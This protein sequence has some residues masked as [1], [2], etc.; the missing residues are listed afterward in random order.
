MSVKKILIVEDDLDLVEVFKL[1][2]NDYQCSSADDT[3]RAFD[4]LQKDRPDLIILD[5]MFGSR[6]ESKGFDFVQNIRKD[7]S[8]SYIPVLIVSAVN[9]EKKGFSFDI[10]KDAEYIPADDFLEKPVEPAVLLSKVAFL[11]NKGKSV[12]T[13]WPEKGE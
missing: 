1:I 2:L 4:L 10:I 6:G 9:K 11:I 7:K 8:F 12:W 13:N 5:V 3:E